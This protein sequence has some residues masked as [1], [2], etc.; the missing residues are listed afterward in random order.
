MLGIAQ[1]LGIT[2]PPTNEMLDSITLFIQQKFPEFTLPEIQNAFSMYASGEMDTDNIKKENSTF[3]A[4]FIAGV[5]NEYRVIRK[6]KMAQYNSHVQ[7][8]D[9]SR[10]LPEHQETPGEMANRYWNMY[11]KIA[12]QFDQIDLPL[13]KW[14]L[15]FR[16]LTDTGKIV[17]STDERADYK[18]ELKNSE[19]ER[20]NNALQSAYSQRERER[21]KTEIGY[22]ND[23]KYLIHECQRRVSI[24]YLKNNFETIKQSNKQ[25]GNNE[26]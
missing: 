15:I 20:L 10:Q 8:I 16:Y 18:I 13:T 25:N 22:F 24:E 19:L 2:N 23:E 21:I 17:M 12:L 1:M 14:D 26:N 11:L 4:V 3:N 9:E 5:L 7:R 6:N